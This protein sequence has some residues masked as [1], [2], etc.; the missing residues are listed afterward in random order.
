MIWV[1]AFMSVAIWMGYLAFGLR[2]AKIAAAASR[3][4]GRVLYHDVSYLRRQPQ[5]L[6]SCTGGGLADGN[7]RPGGT[8]D[9]GGA[10]SPGSGAPPGG[11]GTAGR[12]AAGLKG[13]PFKVGCPPR[14][15]ICVRSAPFERVM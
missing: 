13:L 7:A 12:M 15:R 2:I 14:K 4:I 6:H 3:G 5:S 11:A 8:G 9:P 10:E 1:I